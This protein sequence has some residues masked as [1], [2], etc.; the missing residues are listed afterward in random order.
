MR[1]KEGLL[2]L[3]EIISSSKY[4]L[5]RLVL[6]LPYLYTLYHFLYYHYIYQL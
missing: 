4:E 5:K 2:V 6:V 1:L 3:T